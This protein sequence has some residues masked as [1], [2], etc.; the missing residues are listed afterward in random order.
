MESLWPESFTL[1]SEETPIF[2]LKKQAEKLPKL[3]DDLLY[4]AVIESKNNPN[5][6]SFYIKSKFLDGFYFKVLSFYLNVPFY[7]FD[8][9]IDSD[10]FEEIMPSLASDMALVNPNNKLKNKVEIKSIEDFKFVIKLILG[11]KKMK[12][13]VGSIMSLSADDLNKLPF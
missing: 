13:I 5:V 6:F 8:L 1:S 4:A 10:I 9:N 11:S 12:E 3:T 7:P 2:V